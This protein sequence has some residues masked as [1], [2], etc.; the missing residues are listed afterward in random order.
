M[1]F[2]YSYMGQTL[3]KTCT[4]CTE[5]RRKGTDKIFEFININV[6]KDSN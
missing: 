3:L 2:D 5:E 4:K 1:I 6:K